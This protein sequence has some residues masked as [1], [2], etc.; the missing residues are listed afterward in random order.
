MDKWISCF[1]YF[2][3]L[4]LWGAVQKFAGRQEEE[5]LM[6]RSARYSAINTTLEGIFYRIYT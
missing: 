5:R 4:I 2:I 6:A 1:G 3:C